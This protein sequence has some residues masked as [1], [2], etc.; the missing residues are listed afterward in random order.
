[1]DIIG[2]MNRLD[3]LALILDCSV[4]ELLNLLQGQLISD[5]EA[6]EIRELMK[7]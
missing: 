4:Y 5:E 7:T 3:D 1:M 6:G 2:L